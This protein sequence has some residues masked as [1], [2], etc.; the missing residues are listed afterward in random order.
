VRRTTT[1]TDLTAFILTLTTDAAAT[2]FIPVENHHHHGVSSGCRY[3][4]W[5]TEHHTWHSLSHGHVYHFSPRNG[6]L[7][8]S[9]PGA[10]PDH[11]IRA[12]C[13]RVLNVTDN[14]ALIVTHYTIGW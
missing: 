2:F 1:T 3:P 4:S 7:R 11:D 10:G 9:V 12:A 5:L 14:K 6:T 8:K 13:Y